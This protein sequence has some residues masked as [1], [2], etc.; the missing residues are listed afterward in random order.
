MKAIL[1]IATLVT[2]AGVPVAYGQRPGTS[3]MTP[4]NRLMLLYQ[5][6]Y[7]GPSD[8]SV[9]VIDI[10]YRVDLGFF[11][12]SRNGLES[13]R[14]PLRRRGELLFEF[15]DSTGTSAGRAIEEIEQS[16]EVADIP[17]E[18]HQ[19][20][21]GIATLSVP[22]GSYSIETDL[23]DLES[24]RDVTDREGT[25]IVPGQVTTP[26]LGSV[27]FALGTVQTSFPDTIILQNFGKDFLF[28]AEGYIAS[29]LV[30]LN[31]TTGVTIGYS[32]TESDRGSHSRGVDRRKESVAYLSRP[33]CS[34]IPYRDSGRV[35][36]RVVPGGHVLGVVIPL[37]LGSLPLRDFDLTLTV[38]RGDEHAVVEQHCRSLWPDMPASLRDVDRAIEAL[39]IL[40]PETEVDRLRKGSFESRR[41]SLEAFWQ[42]RTGKLPTAL[43]PLMAEYYRRV[44]HASRSFATLRQPDGLRTDRGRIYVLYGPPSSTE[45]MLS[46]GKPY[47]EVWFYA[48]LNRKF[49]FEDTARNGN[50]VL[51]SS[52]GS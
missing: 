28:G 2:L 50:Y 3:M 7:V 10:P 24:K 38:R 22:P 12:A 4:T 37:P 41:D 39:R 26:G 6:L 48:K 8:S 19:W 51:L 34:Y 9:R 25:A 40:V 20:Y 52:A 46:P 13:A 5:P 32:I 1:I 18:E 35:G 31:D 27:F 17:A 14:R 16:S 47:Q 29:T 44:D 15:F 45:R 11:V 23:T 49:I 36:F 33:G 21:Q 30:G 42:Q 43:N